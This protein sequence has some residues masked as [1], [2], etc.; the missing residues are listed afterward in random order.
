MTMSIPSTKYLLRICLEKSSLAGVDS[1]LAV[2]AAAN[3]IKMHSHDE[4][5]ESQFSIVMG[6]LRKEVKENKILFVS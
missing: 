2:V 5:L 3:N 6:C 1:S 4:S